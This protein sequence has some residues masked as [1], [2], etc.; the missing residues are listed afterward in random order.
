VVGVVGVLDD[1]SLAVRAGFREAGDVVLL[2]GDG[3]AALDGSAYQKVVLG[4]HGGRIPE[5]DLAAER[6]LHEFLAQAAERRLLRSAHDVASG[7]IAMCVAEAAIAGS[8]G[9]SVE[10]DDLFGEGDG[11]VLVTAAEANVPA[12]RALADDLPLRQIGTVGGPVIR[13][14]VA[15]LSLAEAAASHDAGIP[16]AVGA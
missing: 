6:R 13:V 7:G 14:G 15:E 16:K 2:A 5:P 10:A 11:R 1:A 8:V 4:E 3:E 9:A 12:L